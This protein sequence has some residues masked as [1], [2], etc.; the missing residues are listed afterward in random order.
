MG[1]EFIKSETHP[2]HYLMHKYWGRKAHNLIGSLIEDYSEPG[3]TV[4]DPFMGS[5]VTIIEANKSSRN[6]I[7]FDLNPISLLIA[8][9]TLSDVNP[10]LVVSRG[11]EILAE[12]P[13][14][15][16]NLSSRRCPICG[17]NAVYTNGVWRD[18][19]L[20]RVKLSCFNCGI[21]KRDADA[22]D[23]K[24]AT[25]AK[26]MLELEMVSNPSKFP[27]PE[28]FQFV[29]RSGVTRLSG[30]FSP[31][32]LLQ[33]AHI[34][35]EINAIAEDDV[36]E[37]L[38][39]AFTSMLPNVSRMIPA[40]SD[41]VTGKSGWQI[42]KFWVPKIHT[43]KDVASSFSLRLVKIAAGLSEAQTLTTNAEF[44]L[45]LGNSAH[46]EN[47]SKSSVDL[48]IA[49]PP[50]GDSISYLALS[51]FW[52][53]WFNPLVDYASEVIIDSNRGKGISE[54]Q[55]GLQE[56]FMEMRRVIKPNGKL[57]VTFNNRHMRYWRPL[58]ESIHNS[59]FQLIKLDWVDQAV[60]SGTQGINKE[61]TLHGDFIYV[62][63]PVNK[64]KVSKFT[65]INGETILDEKL[66][67]VFASKKR[68]TTAELYTA[69]IPE[70]VNQT[71]LLD[72]RGNNL[73][74]D[75]AISRRC[76]YHDAPKGK[77]GFAGWE[78]RN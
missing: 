23:R 25:R 72:S 45:T 61:S 67:K 19:E 5:G 43:E 38:M 37:A 68:F 16:K 20:V 77:S 63:E 53:A 62:F 26:K 69:V 36:R 34:F 29:R 17:A 78:L 28:L 52:N 58:L 21:Q 42:S 35:S 10:K 44:H 15:L 13:P 32:N 14:E 12:M 66:S 75:L 46:M 30:L 33:I 70:L 49:D 39:V 54:Y 27:N 60:R 64:A 56:I 51:M 76:A 74:I 40:D 4:L 50:Y 9:V 8:R 1:K 11:E 2:K 22:T 65:P 55:S 24:I 7:G 48:V 57:V 18:G 3:D 31:K 41:Q 73:D 59:A 47:V 71:A 6:S